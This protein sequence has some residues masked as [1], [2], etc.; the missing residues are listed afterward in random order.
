[1]KEFIKINYKI[2]IKKEGIHAIVIFCF[3][4]FSNSL[5]AY[6]QDFIATMNTNIGKIIFAKMLFH[7]AFVI[8]KKINNTPRNRLK[9]RNRTNIL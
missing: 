3:S 7:S 6:E 1:M 4:F 2:E 8:K 5:F 9:R